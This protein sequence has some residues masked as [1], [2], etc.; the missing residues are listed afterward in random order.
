MSATV[1]VLLYLVALPLAVSTVG[2]ASGWLLYR[3]ATLGCLLVWFSGLGAV[4][5][6]AQSCAEGDLLYGYG[7]CGSLPDWARLNLTPYGLLMMLAATAAYAAFSLAALFRAL[8][9]QPP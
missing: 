4:I 2:L 7:T 5:L 8:F 9:R 6:V 1:A 3:R